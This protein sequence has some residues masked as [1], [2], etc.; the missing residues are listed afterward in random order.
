MDRNL[1]NFVRMRIGL[2]IITAVCC[3]AAVGNVR[4]QSASPHRAMLDQYCVT[5][6]NER[7]LTGGLALDV[8]DIHDVRENPELWEKVLQKLSTRTMPPKGRPRPDA[9]L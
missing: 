7:L 1:I 9:T 2:T 8:A 5:C 3:G 6:H 4:A